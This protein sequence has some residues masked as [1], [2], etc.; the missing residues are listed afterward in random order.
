MP[1]FIGFPARSCVVA[2][3]AALAL[4]ACASADV[5]A[6]NLMTK[7]QIQGIQ[8]SEVS[9]TIQTPKPNPKLQVALT[10]ELQNALPLC[11]TG[12]TSHRMVV[13]ITD[14]EEQD[15]GKAIFIGDEIELEG[16]V[17]LVDSS[18]GKQ[19]GKYYVE[20]SFFW[21]GI[22]G[23][24]MMADAERKLSKGFAKSICEE[25]FGVKLEDDS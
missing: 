16:W 25:I 3:L 12:K 19:T 6:I 9:V 23:A 7:D 5:A 4:S 2:G 13:T 24:A 8:V 18:T 10:E 17:E 21:G 15:V 11:A 22:I 1:S 14:F 20:R